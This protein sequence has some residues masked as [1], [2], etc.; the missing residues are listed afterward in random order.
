M[1]AGIDETYKPS[2]DEPFRRTNGRRTFRRKLLTWKEEILR[3][4]RETLGPRCRT[5]AKI[6]PISPTARRRRPTAHRIA[7]SRPPAQAD[8]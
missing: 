6:I 1:A 4:S 8:R 7:R 5:R 3:E 2:E